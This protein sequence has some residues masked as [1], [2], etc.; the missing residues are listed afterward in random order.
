LF[1]LEDI[2][3]DQK[4]ER[5]LEKHTNNF[6]E[7]V[8]LGYSRS[9]ITDDTNWMYAMQTY[10]TFGRGLVEKG[11]GRKSCCYYM[12]LMLNLRDNYEFENQPFP[13][14]LVYDDEMYLLNKYGL[15]KHF[16]TRAYMV[17]RL[18]WIKGYEL[19]Y[20]NL[21]SLST[22]HQMSVPQCEGF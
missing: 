1:I 4:A 7:I 6:A 2:I 15:A 9:I 13:G 19:Q 18:T 22:G 20:E 17:L 11:K 5:L 12:G 3:I 10:H 21:L 8:Q 14:G 16:K